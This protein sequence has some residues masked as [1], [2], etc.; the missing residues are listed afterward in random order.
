M[1]NK[2][3]TSKEKDQLLEQLVD[4]VDMEK[5]TEI[6]VT[7]FQAKHGEFEIEND[8]H[9]YMVS[10]IMMDLFGTIESSLKENL[11]NY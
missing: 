8:K 10:E 3:L 2:K 9:Q 5:V 7:L 6:S 11:S 4:A 1:K